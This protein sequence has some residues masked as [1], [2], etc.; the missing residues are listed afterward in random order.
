MKRR[1]LL[2]TGICL[3]A[4][5]LT[6]VVSEAAG[7]WTAKITPTLNPLP[8]GLCGTVQIQVDD[9]TGGGRPRNPAGYLM[10]L[11]DFDMSVTSPGAG[12]VVGQQVDPS[13]WSVC[14]CQAGEAGAVA[15]ITASYPAKRLLPKERVRDVTFQATATVTLAASK[16]SVDPPGCGSPAPATIAAGVPATPIASAPG[17]AKTAAPA[18]A[19]G[20]AGFPVPLS[21]G[22]VQPK[23]AMW[24]PEKPGAPSGVAIQGDNWVWNPVPGASKYRISTLS[25]GGVYQPDATVG[26]TPCGWTGGAEVTVPLYGPRGG[27]RPKGSTGST[28]STGGSGAAS[29]AASGAQYLADARQWCGD[30]VAFAL[31]NY[32]SAV[33]EIPNSPT[34]G[35]TRV[36]VSNPTKLP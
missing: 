6:S 7:Q 19:T 24:D 18:P 1:T 2:G 11:A 14:A 21:G 12:A 36:V 16:G 35:V 10:S 28:G 15:T 27:P 23:T 5:L 31:G 33:F 22:S 8:I 34:P 4:L 25:Y 13:H 29:G 17:P 20:K 30:E 9:G 3:A 32:V 26:G